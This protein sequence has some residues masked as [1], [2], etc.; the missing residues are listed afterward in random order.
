MS[1]ATLREFVSRSAKAL[2]CNLQAC[3]FHLAASMRQARLHSVEATLAR[4]RTRI[5]TVA[6]S[7]A[8]HHVVRFLRHPIAV[9]GVHADVFGSNVLTVKAVHKAPHRARFRLGRNLALLD[10]DDALR[11]AHRQVRSG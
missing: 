8:A 10:H 2:N 9:L 5:T 11:A 7:D 3:E 1:A 6:D 4:E